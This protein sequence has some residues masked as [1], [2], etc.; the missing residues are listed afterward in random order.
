MLSDI[1]VVAPNKYYPND[2]GFRRVNSPQ[3]T[4][5]RGHRLENLVFLALRQQGTNVSYAGE[6]NLWKC[7]FVTDTLAIQVCAELTPFN[8]ARET[9]GVAHACRLPGRRQA[10]VLTLN[11]RD[12]LRELDTT[13]EVRPVWEW[14]LAGQSPAGV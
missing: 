10:L 5:N 12:R 3:T 9:E 11:Q 8:R 2:N 14:L 1:G 6:R 13:V 4:P 7:D